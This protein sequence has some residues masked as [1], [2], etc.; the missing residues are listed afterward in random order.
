MKAI[1]ITILGLAVSLFSYIAGYYQG[2][3][4]IGAMEHALKAKISL[5]AC[6]DSSS[7]ACQGF[8]NSSLRLAISSR[9]NHGENLSPL[10]P[11]I[12]LFYK[13]YNKNTSFI[14]DEISKS[15]ISDICGNSPTIKASCE[16]DV[17]KYLAI[18][19]D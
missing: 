2:G 13:T 6:K 17:E 10:A 14:K 18:E 9:L 15:N 16:A 7:S 11:H 5:T 3:H 19:S 4:D 12:N 8:H 1:I